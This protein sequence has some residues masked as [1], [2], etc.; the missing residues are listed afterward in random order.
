M[1][2]QSGCLATIDAKSIG[3]LTILRYQMGHD[4]SGYKAHVLRRVHRR[5]RSTTAIRLGVVEFPQRDEDRR[6]VRS[7]DQCNEFFPR[8]CSTPERLLSRP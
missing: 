6:A 3:M 5:C 7:V 4:F 2:Q 8:R 1:R